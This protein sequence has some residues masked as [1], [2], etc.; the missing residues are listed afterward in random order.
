MKPQTLPG[1]IRATAMSPQVFSIQ[2]L[3][4]R[5]VKTRKMWYLGAKNAR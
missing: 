5:I 4:A 1:S 2:A 3:L